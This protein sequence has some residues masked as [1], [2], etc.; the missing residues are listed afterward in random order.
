MPT[1]TNQKKA[2]PNRAPIQLEAPRTL[3]QDP[4]YNMD[5]TIRNQFNRVVLLDKAGKEKAVV[6]A[7]DKKKETKIG[8]ANSD[9]ICGL[10]M[11]AIGGRGDAPGGAAIWTASNADEMKHLEEYT[12]LAVPKA[13]GGILEAPVSDFMA[14]VKT[15]AKVLVQSLEKHPLPKRARATTV[16]T[17]EENIEVWL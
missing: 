2:E 3:A 13:R 7:Q 1:N 8:A 4:L 16:G 11:G 15:R 14:I 5:S 17:E 9:F 6:V 12:L 10:L